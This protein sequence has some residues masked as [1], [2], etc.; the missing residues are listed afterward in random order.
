MEAVVAAVECKKVEE[1]ERNE[2]LGAEQEVMPKLTQETVNAAAIAEP[3]A[4][5]AEAAFEVEDVEDPLPD[6][7]AVLWAKMSGLSIDTDTDINSPTGVV[8]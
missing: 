5:E 2:E 6:D 4:N 8:D 3:I 1:V 7:R